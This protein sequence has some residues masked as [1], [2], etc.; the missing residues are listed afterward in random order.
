MADLLSPNVVAARTGAPRRQLYA[1]A[2]T[3]AGTRR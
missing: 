1:R 2:L 3:L